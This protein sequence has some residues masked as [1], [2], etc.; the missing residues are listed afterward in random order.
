MNDLNFILTRLLF[1]FDYVADLTKCQKERR[2]AL[3][4]LG[5]APPGRFAP[6]CDASGKYNKMQCYSA[7]DYCWCVDSRGL[8]IPG[9]RNKGRVSCPDKGLC[10][11]LFSCRSAK[12][13]KK[14]RR[15]GEI[16]FKTTLVLFSSHEVHCHKKYGIAHDACTEIHQWL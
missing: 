9:T 8:E 1:C 7:T 6:E 16:F 15:N 14:S 3:G 2:T 5:S 13:E 12:K 10:L 4:P 11:M